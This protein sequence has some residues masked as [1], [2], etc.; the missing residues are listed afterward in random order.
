[1]EGEAL[2]E[3]YKK[4]LIQIDKISGNQISAE[5]ISCTGLLESIEYNIQY[6]HLQQ[7]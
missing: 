5:A 4:Y 1:M 3:E 6:K 2:L 7:Q